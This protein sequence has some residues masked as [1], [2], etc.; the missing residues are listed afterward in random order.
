MTQR[1]PMNPRSQNKSHKGASRKSAASA[2]PVREAASSVHSV[3]SASRAKQQAKAKAAEDKAEA[4][5]ERQR[6]MALGAQATQLPEYKKWRKRWIIAIVAAIAF[7]AASW[8]FN[9]LVGNGILPRSLESISGTV[10]IVA[11]VL[12]YGSLASQKL[13]YRALA[14][15]AVRP[16]RCRGSGASGRSGDIAVRGRRLGLRRLDRTQLGAIAARR[17]HIAHGD[18]GRA[19][20]RHARRR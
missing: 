2:K 17:V 1:N 12:G 16:W 18:G 20:G 6:E 15:A 10:M 13:H 19:P 5:K 14:A 3:P 11:M 9:A 8:G 7:V 4:K